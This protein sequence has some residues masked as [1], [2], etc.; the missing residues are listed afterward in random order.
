[1]IILFK[2][3]LPL[4]LSFVVGMMKST[5]EAKQKQ[6]ELMIQKFGVEEKSRKRAG[7][8]KDKNIA[9]TRKTLA[10]IFSL[11]LVGVIVTTIFAGIFNPELVI[12]VPQET[13]KH[14]IFS[15][16]GLTSPKIINGYVQLKGVT[17]ALP[18]IEVL[19]VITETIVGF[20]FGAAANRK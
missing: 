18:L 15:F 13:F 2:T 9:W 14:S 12:N 20:Y 16:I 1:M 7:N 11:A 8:I 19:V 5:I 6:M 3:L 4:I 10:L 17:L